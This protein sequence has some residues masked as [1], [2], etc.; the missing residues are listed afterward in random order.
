M[1]QRKNDPTM[2][3]WP[4]SEAHASSESCLPHGITMQTIAP[5]EDGAGINTRQGHDTQPTTGIT[6]RGHLQH[7]LRARRARANLKP[8]PAATEAGRIPYRLRTS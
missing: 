5:V 3:G 1:H 7:G 8:A 6:R 2:W 4:Y